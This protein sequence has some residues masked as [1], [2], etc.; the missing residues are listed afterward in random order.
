MSTYPYVYF[1]NAGT[2]VHRVDCDNTD[3]R[4][5]CPYLEFL[6]KRDYTHYRVTEIGRITKVELNFWQNYSAKEKK[7]PYPKNFCLTCPW[8]RDN[9][10][11]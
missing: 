1:T 8:N 3:V 7:L 4:Y 9:C 11:R 2:S 5:T 10:G 6:E